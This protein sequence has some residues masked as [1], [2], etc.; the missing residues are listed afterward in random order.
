MLTFLHDKGNDAGRDVLEHPGCRRTV[1]PYAI[2]D[3]DRN[4]IYIYEAM[5]TETETDRWTYPPRLHGSRIPLEKMMLLPNLLSTLL[6]LC[7]KF[8]VKGLYVHY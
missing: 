1:N 8:P 6:I 3:R 5:E 2:R 4:Y 7:R